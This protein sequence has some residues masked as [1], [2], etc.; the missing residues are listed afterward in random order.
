MCGIVAYKGENASKILLEC[1]KNLEYRGY[2]SIGMALSVKDTLKNS[3]KI[4]VKKDIGK[5]AD[6][7]KKIDFCSMK[8]NIGIAHTRWATT[9]A[10]TKE[11]SHPHF[12][13]DK[14]VYIVHNGIIENYQELRKDLEQKGIFFN[15]ETDSEVIAQFISY[16]ISTG[17]TPL[18]SLRET[19]KKLQGSYAIAAITTL[20]DSILFARH[21]S[22]LVIGMKDNIIESK[23]NEHNN[24]EFYAASD[25]PAFLAYTNKVMY[26][27]DFEYGEIGNDKEDMIK[28]YDLIT[29]KKK[30]KNFESITWDLEQAKKGNYAH[31]MLKEIHEQKFTIEKA[32]MQNPAVMEKAVKMLKQAYGIFFVACGTSYHAAVS[33]S[34][35]FAHVAKKHVNVVI[36][37]EF[38]NYQ[39]FLTDKTIMVTISQS[40]ETA[41]LL[42]AVKTARSKG[43]KIISIV[44]VMGSTL[45]RLSDLNIM[46]NTGPEICVL[47][48]KSYTS[49]LAILILLAYSFVGK[50]SEGKLLIKKAGEEV[51]KILENNSKK[52]EDIA[53]KIK[54]CT[55]MF[56]I[57]RDLAYPSALE[58][59][60]KIKE[61]SYIHAEGF[62]GGELKHGT[63]ALIEK[64]TPCIALSTD[65][66]RLMTLSNASEVKARG[67]YIIGIDSQDNKVYNDC[68]ITK[69]LGFA[70]PITM[71]I[72]IQLLAY[73]LAI[74]RN[75]DPDKPRNLAKSVTVK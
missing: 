29:G 13:S 49:P 12:S 17:L 65:T 54:S 19:L 59:A 43:V 15:S 34:Y 62:P 55:S 53:E 32:I 31:F 50:E 27:E 1:I 47:S 68:I 66:T 23:G 75:C 37:S 42:D 25:V 52:I 3:F 46:M 41:D 28:V 56:L 74:A 20:S 16:F 4:E 48:T 58:G 10:V 21:E 61:V 38:R 57:G 72:P 24:R 22:P 73:Y 45:M 7:D 26:I 9:G 30:E 67:G 36:A 33:A 63:I 44:N 40:G 69:D 18:D 6:V 71:I 39:E 35:I 11:N 8:G 51:S 5:I 2:D 14:K 70:N 60:L 64:N